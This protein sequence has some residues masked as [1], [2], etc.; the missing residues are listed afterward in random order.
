[1]ARQW[2][3][4]CMSLF[5][6]QLSRAGGISDETVLAL[7]DA[8]HEAALQGAGWDKA[9]DALARAT[10]S[11]TGELIGLG[12][13]ASVPFNIM[14]NIDPAFHAAF[15][16]A[17]GGDPRINPRVMAGTKAPPLQVL[18]DE[19]FI[20]QEAYRRNP[21]Y[22][23]FAI[24]W[25]VP[26]IC[27]T[28]LIRDERMLIGLAVVRSKRE[29]PID[30]EQKHLFQ[31]VAP[32]IRAAVR[33]QMALENKGAELLSRAFDGLSMMAFVCDRFGTVRAMTPRAEALVSRADVLCLRFGR[34]GAV[35]RDNAKA[36]ADAL[37][38]LTVGV[39]HPGKPLAKTVVLRHVGVDNPLVLEVVR[40]PAVAHELAFTPHLLL[41]A[42]D[43]QPPSSSQILTVAKLAFGLTPAEAEIALNLVAG[44]GP[45][46][47][48]AR[49]KTSI[50]TVRL[51]IKTVMA[52]SGSRTRAALVAR[53]IRLG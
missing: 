26:H 1:M 46:E 31:L 10:G 34:L 13:D 19:D 17:G 33:M 27:L 3:G 38:A 24:P 16:A 11:K 41:V 43:A 44:D 6:A 47:I 50:G 20:S 53:L 18:A 29:G 51:Q 48:A 4:A 5:G 14:T 40:L 30:Q 42:R 36:I 8:F 35:Q 45:D 37:D 7:S 12:A 28:N 21:H 23:E 9:L 39:A 52:K 2:A 49:R 32:H 15:V 22:Q 25:G